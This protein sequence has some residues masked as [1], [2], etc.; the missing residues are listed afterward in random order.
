MVSFIVTIPVRFES[1]PDLGCYRC[2]WSIRFPLLSL[3]F[4]LFWLCPPFLPSFSDFPPLLAL[5][6]FFSPAFL[7]YALFSFLTFPIFFF[8]SSH[9]SPP[10]LLNVQFLHLFPHLSSFS[11]SCSLFCL[12]VLHSSV[13][14]CLR[15]LASSLPTNYPSDYLRLTPLSHW[16]QRRPASDLS[17]LEKFFSLDLILSGLS[18]LVVQVRSLPLGSVWCIGLLAYF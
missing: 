1:E 7:V 3:I 15:H 5:A 9:C 6:T 18:L 12:L 8:P 11:K 16:R 4:P 13:S 14:G 2:P 10:P 17:Y